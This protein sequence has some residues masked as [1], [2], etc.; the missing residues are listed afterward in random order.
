MVD[1]IICGYGTIG[2]RIAFA[3]KK[4]SISFIAID[5]KKNVFYDSINYI[6][7]DATS[8]DILLQAGV[9]DAKT[10]IAVTDSDMTNAFISLLV[11]NISQD[12]RV[13]AMVYD[14]NNVNKLDKAGADYIFS[15]TNVGRLIAKNAIEP[16]VADFLDMINLME[17]IE[18]MPVL[19]NEESKIVNKSIKK[20]R[21]QRKTG[22]QII[23]IRRENQTI[24][25]PSE[26]EII[27]P[28]DNL[29]AFGN[30]EQIKALYNLIEPFKTIESN[31]DN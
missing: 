15:M 27:L 8:E 16:Y 4:H 3:L 7:G 2:K 9:V 26:D 30:G 10:V 23:A 17:D 19:V 21:I 22:A 13:L 28:G 1:V 11:K 6:I 14:V 12:I 18:I 31:P 5:R 20:A 25:S 24:Y 29:L